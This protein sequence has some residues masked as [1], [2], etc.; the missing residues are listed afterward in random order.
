[1]TTDP[2]I[3]T[4]LE[5]S[6]SSMNINGLV[7]DWENE[8]VDEIANLRVESL[9]TSFRRGFAKSLAG[10]LTPLEYER[11]TGWDFDTPEELHEHLK[12]LWTKFYGDADPAD[13][14]T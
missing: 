12:D 5:F 14:L 6:A 2:D 10:R 1:M 7:K 3:S 13:S 8:F 9:R 4:F 11:E